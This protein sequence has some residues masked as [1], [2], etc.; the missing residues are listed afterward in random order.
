NAAAERVLRGLPTIWRRLLEAL[1]VADDATHLP[2]LARMCGWTQ[3]ELSV[4]IAGLCERGVIRR[5]PGTPPT[6]KWRHPILP[7]LLRERM[8]PARRALY[9]SRLAAAETSEPHSRG[10]VGALVATGRVQ[11]AAVEANALSS[12]LLTQHRIRSVLEMAEPVIDR[13]RAIDRAPE[14]AELLLQYARCLRTVAPTDPSNKRTLNQARQLAQLLDDPVMVVRTDLEQARLYK[15]IGHYGVYRKYLDQAFEG[16]PDPDDEPGLAAQIAMEFATSHRLQG[17]LEKADHW[18]GIA[19]G[20]AETSGDVRSMGEAILESATCAFGQGQVHEAEEAFSLA[21]E[22][23]DRAG[24]AC[25]LWRSVARWAHTLRLQG[26]YSEALA[27]LYKRLP[28][29]SQ[30]QD[31]V[32]YVELLQATGWVELDLSRLGRAQECVDELAATL[33]R[34]AHLHLRLQNNLLTGRILLASGE[35][36][37]A[38]YVLQEVH[39][40]ARN[41]HLAV[42]AEHARSVLAEALFAVGDFETSASYFQSAILGL[43]GTGD[44][45]ILAEGVRARARTHATREDPSE[46]FRHVEALLG[47]QPMVLLQLENLLAKGA[48]YRSRQDPARSE[49][50]FREAAM[51]LNRMATNLSDTDRA[52]LRVHPWSSWIRQGRR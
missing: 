2:V 44:L 16:L 7:K 11:E 10:R 17:Y 26:R 43:L 12:E 41:A 37:T 36:Q 1:A 18:A 24:D 48:W 51:V 21:M 52:A 22:H 31:S 42:L 3:G 38:T 33:H 14:C 25:G 5:T 6:L 45:T 32:P 49:Q 50:A 28:A 4:A 29:A 9:A 40:S 20:H 46:I 39:R 35:P 30:C 13:L 8:N 23:F 34:G 27:Q 15:V 47:E 19:V